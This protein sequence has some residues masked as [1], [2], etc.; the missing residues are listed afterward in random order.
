MTQDGVRTFLPSDHLAM[1]RPAITR[2]AR[3]SYYNLELRPILAHLLRFGF[4]H[5]T[6]RCAFH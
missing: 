1:A 2:P 3:Q 5:H 6:A 4:V